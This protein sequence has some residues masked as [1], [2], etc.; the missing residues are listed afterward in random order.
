MTTI[1]QYIVRGFSE[2]HRPVVY[3]VNAKS[4]EGAI[5]FVKTPSTCEYEYEIE[6]VISIMYYKQMPKDTTLGIVGY[7]TITGDMV[8]GSLAELEP[9][10][11]EILED[12]K[13]RDQEQKKRKA[14]NILDDIGRGKFGVQDTLELIKSSVHTAISFHECDDH[15]TNP[16]DRLNWVKMNLIRDIMMKL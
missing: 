11:K 5:C 1:H 10:I 13:C 6:N 12:E 8:F 16:D 4:M 2:D 7:N 14:L 15:D 9:K 3:L